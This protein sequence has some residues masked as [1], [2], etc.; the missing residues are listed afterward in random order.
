MTRVSKS[1]EPKGVLVELE[2]LYRDAANFKVRSRAILC[3]ALSIHDLQPYLYEGEFFL[4]ELVGLCSLTSTTMTS[5]D[6]PWHELG[7]VQSVSSGESLMGASE[8][9]SRFKFQSSL[10]WGQW[11]PASQYDKAQPRN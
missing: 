9:V 6:H 8:L 5:D 4:P 11:T 1:N 7:G 3:G 2:Y 10:T